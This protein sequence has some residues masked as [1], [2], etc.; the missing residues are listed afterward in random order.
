M[1]RPSYLSTLSYVRPTSRA[2]DRGFI[3]NPHRDA[4][5]QVHVVWQPTPH[6]RRLQC[7]AYVA[8]VMALIGYSGVIAVQFYGRLPCLGSGVYS[9]QNSRPALLF[10]WRRG[11]MLHRFEGA[12]RHYTIDLRLASHLLPPFIHLLT[13]RDSFITAFL[14]GLFLWPVMCNSLRSDR[15]KRL[16]VRTLWS[17][18]I[19]LTTSC[20]NILVL[21]LMHGR[22]LGWVCL[23]S[24]GADVSSRIYYIRDL[25]LTRAT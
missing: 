2:S 17:T 6:S 4:A 15:V 21:T 7:K 12:G 11:C 3:T 10:W 16:A 22:Q 8:C 1:G 19:A 24:C 14:T 25:W 20:V 9:S 13:G 5:E 23:T 18:L